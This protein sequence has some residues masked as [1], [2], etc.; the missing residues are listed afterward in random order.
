MEEQ[1]ELEQR[2]QKAKQAYLEHTTMAELEL[3]AQ[4]FQA[5]GDYSRAPWYFERCRV[6]QQFAVGN[7]VSFGNLNGKA[8]HWKVLEQRG[9]LRLLFSEQIVAEKA[10]NDLRVLMSW[11]ESSLR[12]WLNH[13][14][15]EQAFTKEERG[16]IIASRVH[17]IENPAYSTPGGQD[18][19]DKVFIFGLEELHKYCPEE[20]DLKLGAWWWTRTPGSNLVSAVSVDADGSIYIPGIN[21]NYEDGGVRPA[22]WVLLKA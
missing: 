8:L 2:Y 14:F 9:K 18:S 6:L 21:I 22:M 20:Q 7:T 15:L 13:E 5:L 19:M 4:Q 17:A 10:Y 16:Q 12:R 3:A 11:K 1:M